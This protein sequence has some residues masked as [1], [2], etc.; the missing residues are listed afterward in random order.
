MRHPDGNSELM[1]QMQFHFKAIGYNATNEKVQTQL[2]Q[3]WIYL[4]QVRKTAIKRDS[5]L[6]YCEAC[7]LDWLMQKSRK[8]KVRRGSPLAKVDILM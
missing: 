7:T 6:L 1:T 3:Q 4:T 8:W 5:C 2:F